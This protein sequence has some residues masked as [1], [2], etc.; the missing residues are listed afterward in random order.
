[1]LSISNCRMMRRRLAPS[2][3]RIAISLCRPMMRARCRVP[4]LAEAISRRKP[5]RHQKD[6]QSR[7]EFS[8]I[9]LMRGNNGGDHLAMIS[10]MLL[11]NSSSDDL[12]L[13]L[14]LLPGD[15]GLQVGDDAQKMVFTLALLF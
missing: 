9:V 15:L 11:P 8:N 3:M 2:A 13:R 5:L 7:A 6:V 10:S 4:T 12:R 1:M 14:S